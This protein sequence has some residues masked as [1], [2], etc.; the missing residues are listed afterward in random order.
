MLSF[1]NDKIIGRFIN[2][3]LFWWVMVNINVAEFA[4]KIEEYH[5]PKDI[6]FYTISYAKW[7]SSLSGI[8][9]SLVCQ[10]PRLGAFPF[11]L[12]AFCLLVSSV[13]NN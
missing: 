7:D 3:V 13:Y 11:A 1:T 10:R 5:I 9:F 8:V 2:G 4:C 6:N 12:K